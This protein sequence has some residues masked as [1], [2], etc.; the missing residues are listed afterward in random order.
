[1]SGSLFAVRVVLSL[2]LRRGALLA[3]EVEVTNCFPLLLTCGNCHLAGCMCAMDAPLSMCVDFPVGCCWL[4]ESSVDCWLMFCISG[5]SP[6]CLMS[7]KLKQ[8]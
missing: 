1:M 8:F 2:N 7:C 5:C 4:V 3:V 6:F